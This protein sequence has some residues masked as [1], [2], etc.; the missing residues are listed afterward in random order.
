MKSSHYAA[1]RTKEKAVRRQFG[2][3]LSFVIA[4]AGFAMT[5]ERLV[6]HSGGVDPKP[7]LSSEEESYA[8]HGRACISG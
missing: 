3:G 8:R 6:F 5:A 4:D 2:G 1:M 7:V